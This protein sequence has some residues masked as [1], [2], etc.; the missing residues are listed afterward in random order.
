MSQD[1]RRLKGPVAFRLDT[2]FAS[3]LS[4]STTG[5]IKRLRTFKLTNTMGY[6]REWH[7]GKKHSTARSITLGNVIDFEVSFLEKNRKNYD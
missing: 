1:Q 2:S 5:L 4:V 7:A 3:Y 6:E